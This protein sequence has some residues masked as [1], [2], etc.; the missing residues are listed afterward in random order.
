LR[1]IIP[2]EGTGGNNDGT[3]NQFQYFGLAS[4]FREVD[5]S[6][7]VDFGYFHPINIVLDGEFVD[8]TAFNKSAVGA[9]AV[10][11]IGGS[12]SSTTPGSYAGGNIGW[13]TRLTVGHE[14]LKQFGD[15]N[16]NVGYKY[17]ESD[18]VVDAFADADFGLGGTNL[19]GY[20]LG[21]NFALTPSVWTSLRWL[22]ADSIAG[23][24]Y[25][26]DVLMLD[27]NAKY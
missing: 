4:A 25:D 9:V 3:I 23:P 17:L 1:N 26:V 18:A 22:S 5:V 19:K 11:N 14:E 13:M 6:G 21:A 20:L 15:W 12:L 2:T 24:T 27:L 16:V 8:N 7:R 10:N